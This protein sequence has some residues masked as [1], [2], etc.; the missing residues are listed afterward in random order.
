MLE[1]VVRDT[2]A[3]RAALMANTLVQVLIEQNEALQ[4]S[5]FSSS[6]A[7]SYTHLTLP[8]YPGLSLGDV[9]VVVAAA[10]EALAAAGGG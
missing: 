5:R 4:T 6:E 2:D 9:E 7:V 8:L 1:V 3:E 10:A